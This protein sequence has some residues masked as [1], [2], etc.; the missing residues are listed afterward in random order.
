MQPKKKR[1][2]RKN[3]DIVEHNFTPKKDVTYAYE[4][5]GIVPV[6]RYHSIAIIRQVYKTPLKSGY[7]EFLQNKE[8]KK[9]LAAAIEGTMEKK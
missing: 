9:F 2:N 7:K 5:E 3:L 4:V 1:S 8:Y 6:P